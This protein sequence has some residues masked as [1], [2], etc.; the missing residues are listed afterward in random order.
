MV[1][2]PGLLAVDLRAPRA[3]EP[4]A[5]SM[6]PVAVSAAPLH[7]GLVVVGLQFNGPA[8]ALQRVIV[9]RRSA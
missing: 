7:P 6:R 9:L 8:E 5:S 2:T 3:S 4:E 1:T